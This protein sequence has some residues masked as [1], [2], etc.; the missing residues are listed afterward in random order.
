MTRKIATFGTALFLTTTLC[1]CEAA[2]KGYATS[3]ELVEALA[4]AGLVYTDTTPLPQPTGGRF[5]FD[6]CVAYS[7]D[8]LWV[9]I[10]R[11][12]D[13]KIFDLAR[14]AMGILVIAQAKVGRE[15]PG[16]PEAYTRQPFVIIVRQ[17]PQPGHVLA[18]LNQVL[19][20]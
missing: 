10:I 2:Q 17:E 11:I 8:E 14:Q 16:K 15:F 5:R 1:A 19:P 13:K 18:L 7:S 9:E 20:E 6:E 4:D 3:A 12:E